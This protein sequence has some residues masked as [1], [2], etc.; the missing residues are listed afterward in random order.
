MSDVYA[1]NVAKTEFREGYTTGDANRVIA[2][3]QDSGFTDMS[4]G[5]S[6]SYGATAIAAWRQRLAKLFAEYSVKMTPIIIDIV[7][8]GNSAYDYGWDEFIFT[9]KSGGEPIRK[10]Q[11]YFELWTKNSRGSWKISMYFTNSDV[12]EELNG[13]VSHWFL[14]E[15]PNQNSALGATPVE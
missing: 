13:F 12:R 10:R 1:I 11:R 2:V 6:S 7:I 9:P 8:T 5:E 15:E 4:E 3:F 14:S